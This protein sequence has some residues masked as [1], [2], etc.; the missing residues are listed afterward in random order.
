M[1]QQELLKDVTC[2]LWLSLHAWP[3]RPCTF[4]AI[5]SCIDDAC[6][7]K[8]MFSACVCYIFILLYIM[9][10][11]VH[12]HH[13]TCAA[14]GQSL[15]SVSCRQA[16][17]RTTWLRCDDTGRYQPAQ[18]R[19]DTECF[20]VNPETGVPLHGNKFTQSELNAD[21]DRCEGMLVM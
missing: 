17:L 2:Q 14:E 20:C 19:S 13:L 10:C 18:C 21:L 16:R 5:T 12:M 3:S 4:I 1:K 15:S 6:T 8:C 7:C 9:V 11:S